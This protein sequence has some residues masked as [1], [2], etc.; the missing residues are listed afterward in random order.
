MPP[1][2]RDS[3]RGSQLEEAAYHEAGHA[4]MAVAI[5]AP[6][7]K[8]EIFPEK[9]GAFIPGWTTSR[10]APELG[11]PAT[12]EGRRE[13]DQNTMVLMAGPT[14]ESMWFDTTTGTPDT[15]E[16]LTS[17][18]AALDDEYVSGLLAAVCA[19]EAGLTVTPG[20]M[21]PGDA[22]CGAHAEAAYTY[23]CTCVNTVLAEYWAAVEDVARVLMHEHRVSARKVSAIV[24]AVDR[25]RMRSQA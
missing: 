17:R 19:A 6:F 7:I 11:D 22:V 5:D 10:T 20:M 8:A 4:V 9:A 25:S 2:Q 15:L 12:A 13:L 18:G 16:R 21:L 3:V 23:I 24:A 1:P 14:A